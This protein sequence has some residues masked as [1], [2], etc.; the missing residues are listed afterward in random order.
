V[1]ERASAALGET[2]IASR[3]VEEG[4]DPRRARNIIL[5]LAACVAL[6]MTGYGIIMPVFARRL[7][8]L[9]GGVGELGM[10]TMAFALAQLVAAPFMGSLADR[11]GRRPVI[12]IALAAFAMTNVAFLF[13]PTKEAFIAIRALEGALT[14]GLFPAAMGIVADV[15]PENERGR[16]VGIVMGSYAAGFVLG[17]VIGGVFY[18]GWGYAAPFAAS[19]VMGALALVAALVVVPETRTD[20]DRRRE[21]LELR[22]ESSI[23]PGGKPSLWDSLPRPHRVFAALLIIDFVIIFAFAFAEPQMVFYLYDDLGFTTVQ[24]GLVIAAYGL[25]TVVGQAGLGRL[26]DRKERRP[27]IV[28]GLALSALFYLGLATATS[29]PV[30]VLVAVVAGVGEALVMSYSRVGG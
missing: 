24:F 14:S 25:V 13:A 15:V 6:M 22:R 3:I 27:I 20:T 26:S 1:T 7:D 2:L 5:L 29:F 11:R 17:P 8:E 18:D 23:A 4:L 12:L 19:A 9:G 10:M 28:T 30:L 21:A 16:W